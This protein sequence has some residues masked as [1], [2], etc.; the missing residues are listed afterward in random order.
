MLGTT[1]VLYINGLKTESGGEPRL[2]N[3]KKALRVIKLEVI[4]AMIADDPVLQN[5]LKVL[6]R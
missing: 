6:V 5:M 3:D 1:R 2:I 4:V